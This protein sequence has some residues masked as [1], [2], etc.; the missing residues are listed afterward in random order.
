VVSREVIDEEILKLTDWYT[1]DLFYFEDSISVKANF[2]RIFCDAERFSDDRQEV[3]AKFGMGVL[4]EKADD[5]TVIRKISKELRDSI[6]SE[7][8][9]P[10]HEKLN[11]AVEKQLKA[12]GK[13]MIVD[14]H[15]FPNIPFNRSLNTRMPRPDF[16]IGTDSFHTPN[17]LIELSKDF[18]EYKGYT[19]GVDWP[20]SGSIVPMTHYKTN[21]D[22]QSIMLEINRALYLGESGNNKSIN[23]QALKETV[24][25][26]LEIIEK[27]INK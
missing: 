21:K 19:V 15:S 18:F 10:H 26:Y 17:Y 20:Y 7:Y 8:Y 1:D 9:W 27:T 16:N 2:S 23:Y 4:Y 3:M 11:K 25:E 24:S 12:N 6:L 5:G 13:A 22:V 14:C